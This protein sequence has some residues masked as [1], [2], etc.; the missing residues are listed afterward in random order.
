MKGQFSIEFLIDIGVILIIIVFITVFF[1]QFLNPPYNATNMQNLCSMIATS[2]DTVSN[3]GGLPTVSYLPVMNITTYVKYNISISRG[4]IIITNLNGNLRTNSIS[5]GAD[6]LATANESFLTSNLA[7]FSNGTIASAA[8]LYGDNG[9]STPGQ[10]FGGGF[11]SNVTL[12]LREPNATVLEI[13]N[14]TPK[15]SYVVSPLLAGLPAGAY[16]MYA[17]EQ[18]EPALTVYFSFSK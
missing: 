4:V 12:Y 5:C 11:D 14:E 8:Y 10:V 17:Q 15:F 9:L 1:S 18:A 6:T 3:S 16:I 7:F 13:A 2:I